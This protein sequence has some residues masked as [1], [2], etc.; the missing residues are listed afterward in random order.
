V[1]AE[2]QPSENAKLQFA[3]A[4]IAAIPTTTVIS[5]ACA[6]GLWAAQL[7]VGIAD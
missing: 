6:S 3:I 7:I 4:T 2:Q 1:A 5:S